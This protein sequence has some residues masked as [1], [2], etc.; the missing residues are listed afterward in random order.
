M[1]E[2]TNTSLNATSG[3]L[4]A[5]LIFSSFLF[6][7][8]LGERPFRNPDEGRYAVV[9]SEMVSSHDWVRP[10]V[11]GLGYQ[12]K[13][14]LFYWLLSVFFQL[15]G[16][17][18]WSA[19]AV[20]ALFGILGVASAAFFARRFFDP[21]TA[22]F[23]AVILSTNAWYVL[24]G[25]YLVMDSLFSFFL[26]TALFL[27]YA[28]IRADGK[29]G[30]YFWAS[31]AMVGL[32][33]LVK[34]PAALATAGFCVLSYLAISGRLKELARMRLLS[35]GILFLAIAS[36]W[37]WLMEKRQS[38][39]L[40]YFVTHEHLERFLSSG[41]EHQ[42]PWFYYAVALPALF[43]PWVLY[44]RPWDVLKTKAADKDL[45]DVLIFLFSSVGAIL[46]FYS[47]SR[48]K[49]ATYLLPCFP[50]L[51]VAFGALWKR[52]MDAKPRL[53]VA[54]AVPVFFL[55][56]LSVGVM[57]GAH[58]FIQMNAG[59]YPQGVLTDMQWLGGA[60]LAAGVLCLRS[61]RRQA[62]RRLFF[63]LALFMTAVIIL[64]PRVMETVNPD[65]STKDFALKIRD[66]VTAAEDVYLYDHPGPFYDFK[67]YLR[68]PVKLVGLEGEL[69]NSKGDVRASEVSVTREQFFEKI[70]RGE[71]LF[72]LMRRSD[73]SE[74]EPGIKEK[75][76]PI[77]MDRRKVLLETIGR[78]A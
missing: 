66:R 26:S 70:R 19:R 24:V 9:A 3:A 60:C 27:F 32:A 45:R 20:P 17:N 33:F 11:F 50:L 68:H 48:S 4:A 18:E 74:L 67:F 42:E 40:K 39:F 35:G 6:F 72:V 75:L 36:P 29:K 10:T 76:R 41:F 22:L 21:E 58:Q 2:K 28:G 47:L 57:V 1:R 78:A 51:A 13:P 54:E 30:H 65:Y 7:F 23:S 69:Q 55:M 8:R 53:G 71:K 46:L 62:P 77:K 59:K 15:F 31:Y 14:P 73:L 64:L 61:I 63:S 49:M 34:G 38:G 43:L 52:W 56:L 25:R 37:F 12:A 44:L 5:A 16:Q